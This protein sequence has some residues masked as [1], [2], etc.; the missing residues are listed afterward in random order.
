MPSLATIRPLQAS[1]QTLRPIRTTQSKSSRESD[2]IAH[3]FGQLSASLR[4]SYS[5][6]VATYLAAFRE[7]D[8]SRLKLRG[9]INKLSAQTISF[10]QAPAVSTCVSSACI[11]GTS[12]FGTCQGG[13]RIIFEPMRLFFWRLR[14]VQEDIAQLLIPATKL[15]ARVRSLGRRFT[16][17]FT[18][19]NLHLVTV[20]KGG[21]FLE[22]RP[23]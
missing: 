14:Y 20:M 6:P 21:L 13:E 9:R 22:R 12:D 11:H 2:H 5:N 16:R 1:Q 18:G 19:R 10:A 7:L 17:D 4:L 23:R 3:P 15:R 8:P